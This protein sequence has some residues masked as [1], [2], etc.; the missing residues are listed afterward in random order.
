M[1]DELR[2]RVLER[3]EEA[4]AG[5]IV[6]QRSVGGGGES[7]IDAVEGSRIDGI[8]GDASGKDLPEVAPESDETVLA[9]G[10]QLRPV[11]D[12][13]TSDEPG[14]RRPGSAQGI[15]RFPAW[16]ADF[17]VRKVDAAVLSR[18]GTR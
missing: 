12:E 17:T 7:G 14:G 18:A 5:S 13:A 4:L 9:V 6:Q 1:F 3:A 8:P 15:V 10:L 2:C 16:E 11:A